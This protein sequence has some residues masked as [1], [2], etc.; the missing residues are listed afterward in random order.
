[1]SGELCIERE[2]ASAGFPAL[3]VALA[4]V[5]A[6]DEPAVL[7]IVAL[8]KSSSAMTGTTIGPLRA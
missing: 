6:V 4:L 5:L 8:A 2:S 3:E 1:V 7:V